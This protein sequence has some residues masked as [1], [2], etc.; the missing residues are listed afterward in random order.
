MKVSSLEYKLA[1]ILGMTD[2]LETCE[3]RTLIEEEQH[4]N[5]QLI[6]QLKDFRVN[7]PNKEE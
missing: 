3:P 7:T 1:E 4:A 5:E 2:I 6:E